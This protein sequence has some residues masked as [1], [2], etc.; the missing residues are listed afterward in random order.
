M[1]VPKLYHHPFDNSVK[2]FISD[3]GF[4]VLVSQDN[5]KLTG[6]H[7]SLELSGDSKRLEGH[8]SKANPQWKNFVNGSEVLAIFT[9]PHAYVSS[10]W[11]DHEN[12]PTWNYIAVHVYGTIRI[13]EGEELL[14]ALTDL[15]DKYEKGRPGRVSVE[16]MSKPFLESHIKAL[17]GFAIDITDV[18]VAKKLSQ[19]R[20]EKN[21]A[22]IVER[23]ENEGDSGSQRIAE[24]MRTSRTTKPDTLL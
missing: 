20:D 4:G 13:T 23:L 21:H 18:Q 14:Q 9:G 17:V 2:K 3:N 22:T 5:G 24:E 15:V 6:T 7:I 10:S 16:T 19:N 12:V 1:Y 11:Y 8:V